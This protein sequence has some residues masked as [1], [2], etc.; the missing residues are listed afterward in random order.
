MLN[1]SGCQ[2]QL[3]LVYSHCICFFS[4]SS[5]NYS[6]SP[7]SLN[8][9]KIVTLIHDAGQNDGDSVFC[10]AMQ[11]SFLTCFCALR[12]MLHWLDSE[13][14]NGSMWIIHS[15]GEASIFHQVTF[16]NFLL[17]SLLME[18]EILEIKW[19]IYP[20]LLLVQW[21]NLPIFNYVKQSKRVLL[22]KQLALKWLF[23]PL[24]E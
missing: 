20:W 17:G 18:S 4:P 12:N 6:E 11:C 22:T 23:L 7:E 3:Q 8:G 13:M 5:V 2:F 16:S 14:Q 1:C 24:M 9:W 19:M 10:Y 21:P 15:N